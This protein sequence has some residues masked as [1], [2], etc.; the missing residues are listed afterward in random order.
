MK[1]AFF[2]FWWFK[3]VIRQKRSYS[4]AEGDNPFATE[5]DNPL[6]REHSRAGPRDPP[7]DTAGHKLLLH[8]CGG[9]LEV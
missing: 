9:S 8:S 5:G 7:E 1:F 2:N 4:D 6:G 3:S